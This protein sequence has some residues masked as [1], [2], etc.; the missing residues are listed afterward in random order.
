LADLGVLD[1]R[2]T[3]MVDHRR[4]GKHATQSFVQARLVHAHPSLVMHMP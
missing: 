3:E 4:D 2:I 1:D